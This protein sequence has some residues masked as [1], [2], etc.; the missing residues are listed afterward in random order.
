MDITAS[1]I[2]R[3]GEPY[4]EYALESIL[5]YCDAA[6]LVDTGSIDH[7]VEIIKDM[8]ATHVKSGR[9]KLVESDWLGFGPSRELAIPYWPEHGWIWKFGHDEIY[10]NN[11]TEQFRTRLTMFWNETDYEYIYPCEITMEGSHV[12]SQYTTTGKP[13]MNTRSQFFRV[14]KT[15]NHY[16]WNNMVTNDDLGRYDKKTNEFKFLGPLC[17]LSDTVKQDS[18]FTAFIIDD[19]EPDSIHFAKCTSS[20]LR[21][22]TQTYRE[23]VANWSKETMADPREDHVYTGPWPEVLYRDDKLPE[24]LQDDINKYVSVSTA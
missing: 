7:T 1:T 10:R 23:L 19:D 16:T 12:H 21:W 4:L 22:K 13:G 3:D 17:G 20:R 11:R 2:L 15:K 5:P 9:W 6:V 24:W 14:D 8:C 18:K